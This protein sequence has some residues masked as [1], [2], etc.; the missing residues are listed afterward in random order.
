VIRQ[1]VTE[2]RE[3]KGCPGYGSGVRWRNRRRK[4]HR[5][6]E[7]EEEEEGLFK[8]EKG[9]SRVDAVNEDSERDQEEWDDAGVCFSSLTVRVTR[10]ERG[11]HPF[12]ERKRWAG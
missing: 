6:S 4:V 9:L 11:S 3:A 10:Y 1:S 2:R 5:R 8:E 12:L 7:E